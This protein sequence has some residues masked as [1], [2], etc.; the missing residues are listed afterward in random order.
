MTEIIGFACKW[1]AYRA[2]DLAGRL[3]LKYP[4]SIKIIKVPCSGRVDAETVMKAFGLGFDGVFIA[5]CPENECHYLNGN[6][7]ARKRVKLLKKLLH[8]L[9]I[10]PAR[11]EFVEISST[12][13]VKFADFAAEFSRRIEGLTRR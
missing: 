7:I 11:L 4:E 12:D 6:S 8:S 9:N 10:E 5:G 1:C 2:I 13:A 3:K